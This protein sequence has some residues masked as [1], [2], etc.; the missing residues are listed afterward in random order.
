MTF[1]TDGYATAH[2]FGREEIMG[3]RA[4]VAE[5]IDRLSRALLMPRAET[6][7]E[8]GYD[9]RIEE[10]APRAPSYATLL[11]SAVATDAHRDPRAQALAE[12]RRLTE[13]ARALLG[14]EIVGRT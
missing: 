9:E 6:A 2:L 3:L 7:P 13:A 10:L 14:A 4:A 5:H 8:A 12:D 1:E 11:G